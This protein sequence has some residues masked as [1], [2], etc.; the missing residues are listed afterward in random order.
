MAKE[1]KKHV[2]PEIE[3]EL[4]N[5]FVEDLFDAAGLRAKVTK[6]KTVRILTEDGEQLGKGSD[7]SGAVLDAFQVNRKLAKDYKQALFFAAALAIN[8]EALFNAIDELWL[9][10][11]DEGEEDEEDAEW[12]GADEWDGSDEISVNIRRNNG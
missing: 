1:K 11:D 2:S 9:D 4:V 3:D 7:I 8:P 5:E 12:N 6:G 10:D